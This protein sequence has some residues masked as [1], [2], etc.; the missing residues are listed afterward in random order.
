MY[1]FSTSGKCARF[2]LLIDG[3]MQSPH[4]VQI[5]RVWHNSYSHRLL[6]NKVCSVGKIAMSLLVCLCSDSVGDHNGWHCCADIEISLIHQFHLRSGSD[7]KFIFV[8]DAT[9]L[10][11][12]ALIREY[13]HM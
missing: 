13:R 10:S 8:L 9:R 4:R 3:H 12:A 1:D 7:L 6:G 11:R 5:A 2:R